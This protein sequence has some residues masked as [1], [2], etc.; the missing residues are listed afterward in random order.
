MIN[1]SLEKI[2]KDLSFETE[3][4]VAQAGFKLDM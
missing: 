3:Y 2:N 4:H 1:L